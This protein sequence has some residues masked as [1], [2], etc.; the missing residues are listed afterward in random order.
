MDSNKQLIE[1]ML[2]FRCQMGDNEAFAELIEH[3]G[4]ALRYFINRL[5]GTNEMTEDIYQDTWLAVIG[6][7]HNLKETESFAPWLYHIAR[8]KV[9]HQLRRKKL[10]TELNEKI[11]SGNNEDNGEFTIEDAAK[12]H[13]ALEKLHPAHKEVLMLRFLE[14]MSYEQMAQVIKSNIGTVKSR[15][16]YAKKALKK[17]MEK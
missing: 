3:Y 14:Q 9:F 4:E 15:I 8:N 6:K 11:I 17:E 13:K 12:V 2:I 16:Y 7:I 5:L 10:L 1:Q